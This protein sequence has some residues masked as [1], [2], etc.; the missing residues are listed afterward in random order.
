MVSPHGFADDEDDD[1]PYVEEK[2]E[3]RLAGQSKRP[4]GPV[5]GY[6]KQTLAYMDY[7]EIPNYWE[8]AREYTLCDLFFSSLLGPSEPNHL[9]TVASQSGGLVYN[10]AAHDQHLKNVFSF[11]TMVDLFENANV[12]WTYYVGNK[13]HR[14]GKWN[15]LPAFTQY[16]DDAKVL[17]HIVGTAKFYDDLQKETLP[18]VCWLVPSVE[19]SE[20]PPYSVKVGMHYVTGLIN[21]VMKS[22]YWNNCAIILV[23]DDFG[24]F[25]DHVPPVQ[26]DMYG[27]GFRVPAIVISPYSTGVVNHTQFDLTS[28]LKLIETKFGLK[29]LTERDA[30]SNNMLDCFNFEQ[31]PRPADIIEDDKKLDF[32]DLTPTVP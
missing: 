9:Y 3:A 11:P 27:F 13:P 32:S 20:H 12:T 24:G 25:Y 2:N 29:S 31:P 28:P 16:H 6:V 30:N 5:P 8:Y 22:S 26:T 21:A 4:T 7:H 10:P 18:Q 15:P 23:W 17:S 19:E 1:D 14:P